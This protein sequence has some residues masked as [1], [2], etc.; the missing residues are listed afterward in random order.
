MNRFLLYFALEGGLTG[1]FWS[2]WQ[3]EILKRGMTLNTLGVFLTFQMVFGLLTDVPTGALADR[4]G[5]RKV[6]LW[7]ISLFPAAF[8]LPVLSDSSYALAAGV[9]FIALAGSLISG[10]LDAWVSDAQAH[11][12]S[13]SFLRRDQASTFGR[14]IGSFLIPASAVF[15]GLD[16]SSNFVWLP[17]LFVALMSCLIAF[18]L[19]KE[20][21]AL[22]STGDLPK[23]AMESFVRFFSDG[24][25]SL[26]ASWAD[27]TLRPLLLVA[28]VMGCAEG[29][30]T[31]AWR[32]RIVELGVVSVAL[33]GALQSL[34]SLTRLTSLSTL[35]KLSWYKGT[36]ALR[37]SLLIG[38]VFW[39]VFCLLDD[40]WLAVPAWLMMIFF[41]V[42]Y[43][44]AIKAAVIDTAFGRD[45][46][47]T[48]LSAQSTL[49]QLGSIS[50][51]AILSSIGLEYLGLKGTLLVG[52]GCL[53]L[54]GA[55]SVWALDRSRRAA[56]QDSLTKSAKLV[57]DVAPV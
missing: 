10:A 23:T 3:P 42:P 14:M 54:A 27:E 28:C 9:L 38:S 2:I 25:T 1:S 55:V 8:L 45:R 48:V 15:F 5:H 13:P 31:L 47:A 11:Q 6:A 26:R 29:T 32:P 7:G 50:T 39:L 52:A 33:L 18:S 4:I 41:Y 24:A 56:S 22:S 35:P 44:S 37:P 21:R 19:P 49:V 16:Q 57:A 30:L 12:T 20:S 46:K 51:G 34:L 43:Y 36:S 17:A 40:P 53:F